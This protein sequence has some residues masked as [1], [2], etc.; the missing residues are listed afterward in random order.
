[1]ATTVTLI[2]GDGITVELIDPVLAVLEAARAE[3]VFD[4]QR[5]G[6]TAYLETGQEMP[7]ATIES[8]RR[9]KVA[10]KGKL[11]SRLGDPYRSPN[12]EIRKHLGLYASVIPVRNLRGL[13]ARHRDVDIVVIREAI[14]D[15]YGGL[16]DTMREGIVASFKV[17][18]AE[19][20][21]RITRF[22]FEYARQKGRRKVTLVHKANIMKVTDGLFIETAEAVARD[23]PSI[24]FKKIIVDNACMQLL[25]RPQQFDVL[26]MG[27]L[28]GAIMSDLAAGIVGGIAATMGAS[29][30]DDIAI[31]ESIHG[32]AQ[33][34]EGKGLANPLPML[35]PAC[36]MLEHVGQH[37]TAERIREA[38][39]R[40][41]EAGVK[42]PDLGG[43]ATTQEMTHAIIAEL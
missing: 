38:V 2:P 12:W 9:N 19:A 24:D 26:L 29:F 6:R 10:L 28:Y 40:A 31:F 33:H 42:T 22:A 7:E 27:N 25:L 36:L 35:M 20:S 30:G 21:R 23:F 4:R 17:V 43:S 8:I 13:P 14:E 18:T 3:V 34:L 37:A 41:L 15:L 5:A 16:E 11:R 39:S 32:D 1:M